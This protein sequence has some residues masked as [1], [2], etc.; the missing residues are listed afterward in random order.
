MVMTTKEINEYINKIHLE[1]SNKK[2][3]RPHRIIYR[4]CQFCGQKKIPHKVMEFMKGGTVQCEGC[5]KEYRPI[6][7]RGR[8][9]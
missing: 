5:G 9:F 3:R 2:S 6:K 7:K 4:N 8:L 1:M